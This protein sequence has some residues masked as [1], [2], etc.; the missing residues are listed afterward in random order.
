VPNDW[1]VAEDETWTPD[2]TVRG[3]HTFLM[4]HREVREVVLRVLAR[5]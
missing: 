5:R 4:N 1:V 3:T 2:V